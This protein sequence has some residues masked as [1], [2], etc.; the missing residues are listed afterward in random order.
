M[1]GLSGGGPVGV[2]DGGRASRLMQWGGRGGR[3][4]Q[5]DEVD[6]GGSVVGWNALR[7][8]SAGVGLTDGIDED[9]CRVDVG[10]GLLSME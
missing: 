5:P 3:P 4:M 1:A 2:C 7:E 9:V 8:E 6:D 10:R